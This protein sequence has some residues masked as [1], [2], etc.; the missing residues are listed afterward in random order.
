[1][2]GIGLNI[3]TR[4][5]AG[6]IDTTPT[7]TLLVD[8]TVQPVATSSAVTYGG[9]GSGA[10]VINDGAFGTYTVTTGAFSAHPNFG[11][12]GA[13]ELDG[14]W[15]LSNT[16]Q[17]TTSSAKALY[18]KITFS[19]DLDLS[20]ASSFVLEWGVPD[21]PTTTNG[22][23]LGPRPMMLDSAEA[24]QWWSASSALFNSVIPKQ[25]SMITTI[26]IDGP[27]WAN[28]VGT[29]NWATVRKVTVHM[30]SVYNNGGNY[31][32]LK[33]IWVNRK[34]AKAKVAFTFDDGHY[35]AY[36][37]AY[38]VL[39]ARNIKAGIAVIKSQAEAGD[40]VTWM[41]GTTVKALHDAGWATY[42][43]MVTSNQQLCARLNVNAA[44]TSGTTVV[45][46]TWAEVVTAAVI[47]HDYTIRGNFGPEYNGTF[48]LIAKPT[49]TQLQFT[50]SGES[51]VE[52]NAR[53]HGFCYMDWPEVSRATRI[54]DEV[55]ACT[56]Y[57]NSIGCSRGT[58]FLVAPNGAIDSSWHAEIEAAG[59][60]GVRMTTTHYRLTGSSYA[61]AGMQYTQGE[62]P[63]YEMCSTELDNVADTTPNLDA[64]KALID[65]ACDEGSF[66]N[67]YGHI[68]AASHASLTV[69][70]D[71]LGKIADYVKTKVDAGLMDVVTL[72]EFARAVR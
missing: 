45:F 22:L 67:F 31:S 44:A 6:G 10:D 48:K 29:A 57:L 43:H 47:G 66:V 61:E 7:G 53:S 70:V 40:D 18:A 39:A 63:R 5:G 8:F 35:T 3:W 24:N 68:I 12:T 23:Y 58:D 56:T 46:D 27:S 71:L 28:S 20:T 16:S 62:F 13:V 37:L 54:A 9:A 60:V 26:P 2:I 55:V 19:K 42:N 38:P 25:S 30:Y 49:S 41:T 1:M 14:G 36:S 65:N 64:I 11:G 59:Y 34:N 32:V 51:A 21:H 69:D 4:G 15:K 17:T 52:S 50:V 72:D 33:R